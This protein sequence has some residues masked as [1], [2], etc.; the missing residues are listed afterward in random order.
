MAWKR[1]VGRSAGGTGRK[2]YEDAARLYGLCRRMTA[3]ESRGSRSEG[4]ANDGTARSSSS[5]SSSALDRLR[6]AFGEYGRL[7]GSAIVRQ[8]LQTRPSSPETAA[9]PP[10]P[11]NNNN[12]NNNN[13]EME[14]RVVPDLL[15]LKSHLYSLLNAAF[16]SEASFGAMVRSVLEDVLN[17]GCASNSSISNDDDGGGDDGGRRIAELLAKHVDA[18]FKDAKA[19]AAGTVAGGGPGPE[20]AATTTTADANESFQNEILALFRHVHSKDVF[21]AFYKRDLA[22]R[23]LTG[24]SV[25]T[26]ME[27]SFLSKLKAECGAGYTS[28]MEGMFK[29]MELSRDIMG[30][31]AAYSAGAAAQGGGPPVGKTVDMD[32]QVLTTGYWP[33]YPKYP[34]IILPPELLALRTKFETYYDDKYQGRRIAWQYSLGNC[35]VKASF[36]K[37]VAPKELIVNVCQ[38]LVL[39]CFRQEDGEDGRGLT[40]DEIGKRTGIEDRAELERVL[41]SLSMGRDG[42]RV[43]KKVDYDSPTEP[44]SSPTKAPAESKTAPP[45]KVKRKQRVRRNV[46]PHDRF[47]FNSSFSSNQRRIRITNITMKETTEER[48]KTHASVSKDRLYFIDAAVVRIMK[49]RKMIDHRGLIGEVMA[50]LKFPATSADIKKRIESLIERE[51]ME[52]VEED[53]SRYK[54]LA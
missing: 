43:L 41:Q 13:K 50:Q 14:K 35:I 39:L 46:G 23:L 3:S 4:G 17:G 54:Y 1:S 29:D 7:R 47:L 53:R 48:T 10:S 51:Y 6:L 20:A 21:E 24:R 33:V 44:H 5:S 49:A 15:A 31:Y 11:P 25:S 34:N 16:R 19:S 26:D 9:A 18:R 45:P 36:P 28:K 40:L 37:S 12:N 22:K 2:D 27:R 52:R 42:T 8:G 38:S 32:V 30:S